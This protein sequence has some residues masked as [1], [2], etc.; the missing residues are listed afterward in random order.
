[1]GVVHPDHLDLVAQQAAGRVE[2]IDGQVYAGL[3]QKAVGG[4]GAGQRRDAADLDGV[5]EGGT[6]APSTSISERTRAR[7][8]FMTGIPPLVGA[9][10]RAPYATTIYYSLNARVFSMAK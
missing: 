2:L 4:S 5:R 7:I 8:F 3:D 9:L 10:R 1:M 6:D